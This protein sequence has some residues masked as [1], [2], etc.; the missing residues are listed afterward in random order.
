MKNNTAKALPNRL[1]GTRITIGL[2]GLV[3]IALL[4]QLGQ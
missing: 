4:I 3:L 2:T 1:I